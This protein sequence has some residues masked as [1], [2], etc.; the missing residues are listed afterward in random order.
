MIGPIGD[1]SV[2]CMT[3]L[4]SDPRVRA[5]TVCENDEPLVT[6]PLRFGAARA[7]VRLTLSL[8]LVD[9]AARLPGE[10]GLLVVE[11]YRSP[12]DQ[13]AII[14][15]YTGRLRAEHPSATDETIL[16]LSSRFVAPLDVAPHVAG[17]AIDVTLV[18]RT[19]EPLDMGTPI[20]AI[21]EDTADAGYFEATN[22]SSEARRNRSILAS[23]LGHAGFVNY[24]TEWWHWSYGDRY[25]ALR[26]NA[27]HALYGPVADVDG[28]DL[29]AATAAGAA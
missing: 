26:A 28:L 10:L 17:A 11:G 29:Q 6:I 2:D 12:K 19:G 20:D 1:R 15:S 25:W 27:Q 3:I 23:A 13:A 24:P 16:Q 14:D 5:V 4:L 7:R 21:P 8:R 9:A 18:D 22:I